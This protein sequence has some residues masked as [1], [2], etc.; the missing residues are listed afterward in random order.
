MSFAVL[1][2]IQ[3]C[4][5]FDIVARIGPV[6]SASHVKMTTRRVGASP[7]PAASDC[8]AFLFLASVFRSVAVNVRAFW[9]YSMIP[10]VRGIARY[11]SRRRDSNPLACSLAVQHFYDVL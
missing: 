5:G 11:L 3:A 2:S 9:K 1:L 7:P 6:I 8:L 4:T 10:S